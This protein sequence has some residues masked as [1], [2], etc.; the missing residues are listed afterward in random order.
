MKQPKGI[1][2]HHNLASLLITFWTLLALELGALYGA[3]Y[4]RDTLL[5]VPALL[6]SIPLVLILAELL[7]WFI[8]GPTSW[9]VDDRGLWKGT[10]DR[11][12]QKL[13]WRRLKQWSVTYNDDDQ[14]C[15]WEFVTAAGRLKITKGEVADPS[16]ELFENEVIAKSGKRPGRRFKL[17][18]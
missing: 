17:D 15:G 11:L 14:P 13:G 9:V 18:D 10:P 7:R 12:E 1:R 6:V 16:L 3:L 5:F 4:T 8:T 2:Y